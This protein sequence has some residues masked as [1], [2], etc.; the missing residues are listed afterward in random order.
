[1]GENAVDGNGDLRRGCT[2]DDGDDPE[3]T[4]M[5]ARGAGAKTF[6]GEIKAWPS[7]YIYPFAV[8]VT[9]LSNSVAPRLI[10][11]EQLY[12]SVTPKFT[13]RLHRG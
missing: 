5:A 10:T 13:T 4:T 11:A 6:E 9:E 2:G 3:T 7:G 1:M 8:G 12:T